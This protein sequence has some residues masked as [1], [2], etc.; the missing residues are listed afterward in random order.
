MVL[1]LIVTLTSFASAQDDQEVSLE[2]PEVTVRLVEMTMTDFKIDPGTLTLP[3]GAITFAILN[4]GVIDHNLAIENSQRQI[5]ATSASFAAGR[6]G[7][8]D[9]TLAPGNYTMVCTL[10]AHREAG[11]VGT[12]TI[13]E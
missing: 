12:L 5:L 3:S 4:R 10:P 1:G 2:T 7:T 6:S 8:F 9:V 13:T 11:M